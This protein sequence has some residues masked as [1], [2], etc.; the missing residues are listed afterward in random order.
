M[1]IVNYEE[2]QI[3]PYKASPLPTPWEL[4]AAIYRQ[5]WIVLVTV[6]IVA[7]ALWRSGIW[8]PKYVL[9]NE[10]PGSSPAGRRGHLSGK[11]PH[12]LCG[13]ATR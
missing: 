6:A 13:A 8:V 9:P 2:I 3:E 11:Q 12:L 10:N 5:R 1:A 7:F 4:G